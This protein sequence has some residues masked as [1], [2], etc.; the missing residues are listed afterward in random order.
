MRS[1]DGELRGAILVAGDANMILG[2]R[3]PNFVRAAS[4]RI[5]S[6]I[7]VVSRAEISRPRKVVNSIKNQLKTVEGKI[8]YALAV[9]LFC[10]MLVP[11]PY[12]VRCNCELDATTRRF[13]IAPFDGLVKR[14]FVQPGDLVQQGQL[15]ARM[16][17]QSLRF[18]MASVSADLAKAHKQREIELSHRNIPKSLVA[19]FEAKSLESEQQLLQFQEQQIEICSPINGIVLSGNLE[20]A[21]GASV[22]KGQILFEVGPIDALNVEIAIPAEEIAQVNAGQNVRV[23]INGFESESFTGNI[24][25]IAPRSELKDARNV[26]I[27]QLKIENPNGRF[28]PGMKGDIRIDCRRHTLF[29]NLFHKPWNYVMSRVTWW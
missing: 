17:G 19:E 18:R 14:G 10:F 9:V 7:E 13:A 27:A 2:E 26:F 6:A 22:D 1:P 12:R 28:R 25:S 5:A 16:D 21:E 11:V 23:W 20:K 8:W 4:P 15:L 3:L 24:E 29:W